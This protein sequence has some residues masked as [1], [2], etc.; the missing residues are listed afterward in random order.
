MTRTV[1]ARRSVAK[2]ITYGI[3]IMSLDF[4]TIYLFTGAVHI[5]SLGRCISRWDS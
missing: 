1:S 2:A 3:L 4:L 5:A